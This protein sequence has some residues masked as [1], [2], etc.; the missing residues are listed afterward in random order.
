MACAGASGEACGGPDRLSV[1]ERSASPAQSS[2]TKSVRQNSIL[3]S[4]STVTPTSTPEPKAG[5]NYEG[6]YIDGAGGRSLPQN[7]AV[8]GQMTNEKCRNS[9]RAAGFVI[10]GT[11]Y[12]GEC[13]N[14]GFRWVSPAN[15]LKA[16]VAM[17]LLLAAPLRQTVK[18][19]AT[20][21]ATATRLKCAVVLIGYPSSVSIR[22]T[23]L[24]LRPPQHLLQAPHLLL[25]VCLMVSS[26]KAVTLMDRAFV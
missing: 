12:Y 22:V 26:T 11:E 5:W 20:H 23:N 19:C 2:T 18:L 4:N 14:I 10:A 24:H 16:I 21:L 9:C 3:S 8:Q 25:L 7:G 15:M 6:C 17:H 1:Y 13:M